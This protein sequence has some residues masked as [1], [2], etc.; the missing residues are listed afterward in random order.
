MDRNLA[1]RVALVLEYD[2]TNYA[3]WQYQINANTVQASLEMALSKL[4]RESVPVRGASRT[5]AGVHARGQ[6]A[7]LVLPRPF[8]DLKLAPAINWYLPSDIRVVTA[9]QVPGDFHPLTWATGKIYKYYIFNRN[10]S[11]AIGDKYYWHQPKPLDIEAMNSAARSLVGTIDFASFQAAGSE[12]QHTIR[13]L[14]HVFCRRH[15]GIVT[16]TCVGDGFLYNMVR[17]IAGTLVEV[18]LGRQR[19]DWVQSIIEAR[20]RK[21]AGPTAPAQGLFLERVLYR[22]SLDSYRPL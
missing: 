13:T 11:P 17:I 10:I 16:V 12:V 21:A 14:R 7:S 22:P 2:G 20:D 8:P 15:G 6:V 9:H 1:G 18:G 4:F 3:G 19:P 5:D